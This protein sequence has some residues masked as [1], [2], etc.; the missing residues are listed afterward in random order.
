MRGIKFIGPIVLLFLAGSRAVGQECDSFRNAASGDLVSFLNAV[1]PDQ[2]NAECVAWAIKQLGI[3]HCEPAIIVLAKFLDFRRPLNAQEKRGLFLH[4]Q[5]IW[6]I[7]PAADAL[8]QF[9][10]KASPAVLRA[11]E[12]DSTSAR[13]RENAVFVWMEIHKYEAPNGV[14]LLKQEADKT[15]DDAVKRRLQS[16]LSKAVSWCN[17]P[18]E[19]ACKA[20]ATGGRS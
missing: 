9:G 14:A 19:T 2:N 12:A 11:I 18:D 4:P 16:A 20:A 6:E 3:Q 1:I 17:P 7:Y 8:G 5:G 13:A 15:S 10:E